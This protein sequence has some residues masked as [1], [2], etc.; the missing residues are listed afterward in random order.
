MALN[1]GNI[2]KDP[3]FDSAITVAWA[4]TYHENRG[5][6]AW[7]GLD[8]E[9]KEQLL[10][11]ATD[12]INATYGPYWSR[13]VQAMNNAPMRM[14]QATAELALIAATMPLL[15]NKTRGKKRV[16][17]GPLE[18]EYDGES[19]V[20]TQFVFAARLLAPLLAGAALGGSMVRLNRC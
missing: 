1:V 14:A 6:A 18:V 2:A 5:N 16:K 13:T 19:S 15:S 9:V 20:Q 11:K 4:D 17:V 7:A 12:F 3:S 8:D 10:R